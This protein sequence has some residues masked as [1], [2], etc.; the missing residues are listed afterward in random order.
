[1]GIGAGRCRWIAGDLRPVVEVR[2]G[3]DRNAVAVIFPVS[4]HSLVADNAV[5]VRC[6]EGVSAIDT[7]GG[8]TLFRL[9]ELS[10]PA[11]VDEVDTGKMLPYVDIAPLWLEKVPEMPYPVLEYRAVGIERVADS[12]GRDEVPDGAP[13]IRQLFGPNVPGCLDCGD[14]VVCGLRRIC[15]GAGS[16]RTRLH[17]EE[18]GQCA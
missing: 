17:P 18:H 3:T 5:A 4:P 9:E 1:M 16:F 8:L 14:R 7:L 10:V 6:H 2:V 13:W 15:Y 12:L 11:P